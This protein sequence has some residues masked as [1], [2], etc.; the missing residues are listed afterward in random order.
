MRIARPLLGR[1]APMIALLLGLALLADMVARGEVA[2]TDPVAKHLPA[3]VR[4]PSRGSRQITLQDLATHRSG[5][6]RWPDNHGPATSSQ[7]FADYP[8]EKL[9]AFLS[10]HSLRRDPGTELEYSNLGFGLLGHAL[11]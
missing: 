8:I 2:L 11:A 4:V 10:N 6:P 1:S 5:L 7:H 3:S 9:Y